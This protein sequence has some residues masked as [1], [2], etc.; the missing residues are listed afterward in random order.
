MATAPILVP[1]SSNGRFKE[2]EAPIV[3]NPPPEVIVSLDGEADAIVIPSGALGPKGDTGS[4]GPPG[5]QGATG[6]TGPQ[7]P[8]GDTGATGATGSQGPI[9]NTGP[10]G[11]IGNT[12][13]Q[14]PIGDTGPTG[15]QGPPGQG[16]PVGG[17]T[18][19]ILN[20]KSAT[21]YDTQWTTI[22]SAPSGP[23]GGD[24]SGTYPNPELAAGII[25]D[26]DVNSSAA[27]AQSKIA[28][29]TTSLSGKVDTTRTLTAG[30]GLTGGGDL[31]ANRS[32]DVGAGTGI[33]VAAD[34]V[35][36]DTTVIA[37]KVSVDGKVAKTGDT[38]TG[39]LLVASN[40]VIIDSP[41]TA[42]L[43]ADR[44]T[45]AAVAQF[46]FRT[47]G[48]QNYAVGIYGNPANWRVWH[49]GISKSFLVINSAGTTIDMAGAKLTS[50][51]D[52]TVATDAATK[53]YVDSVAGASR[54]ISVISSN[55]TLAAV[56]KTDYMY[57]CSAALTATMPTAVG[58]TNLYT[59]KRTGTGTVTVATTGGQTIDGV[60]TF[61]I[62]T[63][64]Q[65]IGLISDGTNW[66]VV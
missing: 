31:S 5:P 29:L 17:T 58:N 54:V 19:Q 8:K 22:S 12:G 51:A 1:I 13:P 16:I 11:P 15:S 42:F 32:L 30:A 36:V 55:T 57:V 46:E 14:G 37:T 24:L 26:A 28:G 53:S 21:D 38:M 25:V 20:K 50:V 47:A 4:Q 63:Q 44:G 39:D 45:T 10:Q 35:A 27:I 23:A 7:G 40:S 65:A 33:T 18:G 66:V 62:N 59:I 34:S 48:V 52:P 41:G 43:A 61:T 60:S 2:T 9:G 64:Y 56:A 6:A 3:V 49:N